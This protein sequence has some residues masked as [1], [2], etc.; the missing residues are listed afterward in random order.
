[1]RGR[2][3]G[4]ADGCA[5]CAAT[6]GGVGVG[7]G[8]GR[9]VGRLPPAGGGGRELRRGGTGASPPAPI[10]RATLV[11]V[12]EGRLLSARGGAVDPS[13]NRFATDPEAPCTASSKNGSSSAID[14]SGLAAPP[15][16]A[17]ESLRPT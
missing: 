5:G 16:R 1:M 6:G 4:G 17:S 3:P 8:M 11:S 7:T 13:G 9:S 12:V 2:I 15:A 14:P 10:E